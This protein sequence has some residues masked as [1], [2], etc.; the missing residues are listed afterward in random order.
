MRAPSGTELPRRAA[1][2]V[3]GVLTALTQARPA[4]CQQ[5]PFRAEWDAFLQRYV[6]AEGRVVDTGNTGPDPTRR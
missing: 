6:T 5:T 3:A 2:G 1:L 4:A